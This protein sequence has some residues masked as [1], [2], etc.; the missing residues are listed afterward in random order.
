MKFPMICIKAS[1][2]KSRIEI[3]LLKYTLNRLFF[4]IDKRA[5]YTFSLPPMVY[6]HFT[7]GCQARSLGFC[8]RPGRN[9]KYLLRSRFHLCTQ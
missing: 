2:R 4:C 5:Q 7:P 8:C 9:I 6:D 1:G 3:W